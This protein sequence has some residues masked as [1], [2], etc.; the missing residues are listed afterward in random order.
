MGFGDVTAQLKGI[1]Q[2]SYTRS[3]LLTNIDRYLISHAAQ[4]GKQTDGTSSSHCLDISLPA[5]FW[6]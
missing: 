4:T 1:Q 3:L 5:V 2:K 6:K